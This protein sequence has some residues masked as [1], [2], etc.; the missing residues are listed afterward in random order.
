MNKNT[1][2]VRENIKSAVE[3]G[4]L[5]KSEGID[6]S[7]FL[8]V[9]EIIDAYEDAFIYPD[10]FLYETRVGRTLKVNG[11]SDEQAR[12]LWDYDYQLLVR[13]EK[14]PTSEDYAKLESLIRQLRRGEL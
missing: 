12:K 9:L 13:L 7:K 11:I 2:F 6:F 10:E 5:S 14:K 4:I 1:Y 3:L 8:D